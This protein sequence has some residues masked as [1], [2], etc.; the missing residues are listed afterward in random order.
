[1]KDFR[2]DPY[3]RDYTVERGQYLLADSLINNIYLSLTTRKGSWPFAPALGSE[4][5]LLER[6]KSVER[7][8]VKAREYCEKAL[9]WILAEGRAEKIEV[10][11]ALDKANGRLL[12]LI[13]ATKNGR[14]IS[15]E[16]FVEVR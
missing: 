15:Y 8:A 10:T 16:H 3:S 14:Q 13:E 9:A 7:A 2:I 6:E 11:T 5:H 4:L 1:M 12:C